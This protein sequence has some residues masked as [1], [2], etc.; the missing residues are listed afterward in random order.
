[1]FFEKNIDKV[2]YQS[3]YNSKMYIWIVL[4][5]IIWVE[6]IVSGNCMDVKISGCKFSVLWV[7]SSHMIMS[8]LWETSVFLWCARYARGL[9]YYLLLINWFSGISGWCFW[10]KSHNCKVFKSTGKV[11]LYPHG[12]KCRSRL[13][14]EVILSCCSSMTTR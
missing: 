14:G 7:F 3:S 10:T 11:H 2:L 13:G 6:I 4:L 1:M 8:L 9:D 12:Y 5:G